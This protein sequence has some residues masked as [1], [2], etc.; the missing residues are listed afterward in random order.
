MTDSIT[1]VKVRSRLLVF[2]LLAP[3][4]RSKR[5]ACL[6]YLCRTVTDALEVRADDMRAAL[7]QVRKPELKFRVSPI[8]TSIYVV[9]REEGQF[10]NIKE[11]REKHHVTRCFGCRVLDRDN[12]SGRS[13]GDVAG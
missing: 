1:S 7:M 11:R 3:Q 12:P 13:A 8:V 10:Q 4:S 9:Y 2:C 6:E 5:E